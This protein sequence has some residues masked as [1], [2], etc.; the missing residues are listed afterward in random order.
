[1]TATG[2]TT[3]YDFA[4]AI[5]E[6]ASRIS[7]DVSWFA[8]ATRGR[9]LI[10][11]RIIPITTQE[12]PTPATRPA[13]SVLSNSLLTRTLGVKM[14]DWRVQLRRGFAVECDA[15]QETVVFDS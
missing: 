9:P 7:P 8:E 6:E 11:R 1:M 14:D 10:T 15:P 5:L 12:Y 3:W 4:G 2:E 13:Y